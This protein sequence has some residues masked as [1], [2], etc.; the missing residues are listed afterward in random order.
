M[1][2]ADHAPART[3]T[4]LTAGHVLVHAN[5]VIS[6]ATTSVALS[7]VLLAGL[8]V[9][10]L[11]LF[12]V[13]AVTMFV[14]SFNRLAD[15]TED[16]QN[17]PGR[18]SFVERYGR[19][20]LGIGAVLYIAATVLAIVQ[21]V[22]GAPAMALPLIVAVLYSVVGLKRVLLVKNL[23]V[24]FA[25]G[26]IPLG[27]GVYYDAL[28]FDVLAMFG[29]VASMITIAAAVFDIKDIEGDAAADIAT[30]PVLY[31]P[32][33]TRR[34]AVGATLVVSLGLV[35]AVAVG[36]LGTRYLLLLAMSGYVLA[37]CPFATVERG[38]LFYG[39]V[40]DGEHIFLAL[41]VVASEGITRGAFSF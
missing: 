26:L 17:T 13:F 8:P 18:V 24:G 39:L 41:V 30:L 22:P 14:Y 29:F 10:P 33:A 28:G 23:L 25:W 3:S 5:V 12:I 32:R 15:L 38:P 4:L 7:T 6:L 34:L 40:V 16:R 9:D 11:A 19:A 27:V 35:A 31:G 1:E 2:T 20:L 36:A 37:Y 21:S